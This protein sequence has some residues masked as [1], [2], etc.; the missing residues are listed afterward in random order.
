MHQPRPPTAVS[1]QPRIGWH[2]LRS[3]EDPPN[4]E[5]RVG[6]PRHR[7]LKDSVGLPT[8]AQPVASSLRFRTGGAKLHYSPLKGREEASHTGSNIRHPPQGPLGSDGQA[9][10]PRRPLQ[11]YPPPVPTW[12]SSPHCRPVRPQAP[13]P[14]GLKLPD[15]QPHSVPHPGGGPHSGQTLTPQDKARQ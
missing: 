12:P 15:W 6:A 8:K 14:R 2:N 7:A 5:I 11:A 13:R 4:D 1:A 3:P 9:G 10:P